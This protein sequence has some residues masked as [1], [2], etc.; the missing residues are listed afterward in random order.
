MSIVRTILGWVGILCF[1]YFTAFGKLGDLYML[2]LKKHP[3]FR[4]T[5]FSTKMG[6]A[7]SL[8]GMG[9]QIQ[10]MNEFSRIYPTIIFSIGPNGVIFMKNLR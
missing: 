8:L 3:S 10:F 9:M 7:N 2:V 6:Q 1:V 4:G 5:F